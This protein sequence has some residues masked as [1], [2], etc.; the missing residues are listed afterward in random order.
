MR[1]DPFTPVASLPLLA[2]AWAPHVS[3]VFNLQPSPEAERPDGE[4]ALVAEGG[5][6][7]H[8][9]LGRAATELL[10]H[11]SSV[12]LAPVCSFHGGGVEDWSLHEAMTMTRAPSSPSISPI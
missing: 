5:G 12:L 7:A 8:W 11:K 9:H 6:V 2:D 1:N 3:F 10:S 4:R